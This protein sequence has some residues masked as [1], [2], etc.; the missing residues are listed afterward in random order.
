MGAGASGT[1]FGVIDAL[2]WA[3]IRNRGRL[4]DITGRQLL[5]MTGISLYYGFTSTS[6]DNAAHIGG[7]IIGFLL[8][9][10]LYRKPEK[11]SRIDE[12]YRREF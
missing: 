4:K 8:S 1:V 10:L 2:L 5:I 6:I 7:F 11:R 12:L 9:I 3:V